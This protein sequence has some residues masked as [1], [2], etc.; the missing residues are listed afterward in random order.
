MRNLISF[1]PSTLVHLQLFFKFKNWILFI[2]MPI[3]FP[4]KRFSLAIPPPFTPWFLEDGTDPFPCPRLRPP[5]PSPTPCASGHR[6]TSPSPHSPCR[7]VRSERPIGHGHGQRSVWPRMQ[8]VLKAPR[9]IN[10]DFLRNVSVCFCPRL[11]FGL[12]SSSW[13]AP[14]LFHCII[15]T[16]ALLNSFAVSPPSHNAV[17]SRSIPHSIFDQVKYFGSFA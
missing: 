4:T 9:S 10:F 6:S 17:P 7:W 15:T 12:E 16:I 14:Q 1:L 13:K 3:G 8:T 2:F 11:A 5:S